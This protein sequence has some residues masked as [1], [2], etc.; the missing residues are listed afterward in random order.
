MCLV[1]IKYEISHLG[2]ET[3]ENMDL[4]SEHLKKH[5]NTTYKPIN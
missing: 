4:G 5:T 1:S 3:T 2:L